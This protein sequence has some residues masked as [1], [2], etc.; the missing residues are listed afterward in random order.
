MPEAVTM[1]CPSSG[2]QAMSV[3]AQRCASRSSHHG[4]FCRRSQM[5][6]DPLA[7]HVARMCATWVFHA[8]LVPRH[9]HR[10]PASQHVTPALPD[11]HLVDRS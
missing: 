1:F 6:V 5:M 7:E 11:R 10:P 2:F 4:F 8:T 3:T 9:T